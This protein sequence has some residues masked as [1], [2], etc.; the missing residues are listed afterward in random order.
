MFTFP[1]QA[2]RGDNDEDDD[3]VGDE[4]DGDDSEGGYGDSDGGSGF[5]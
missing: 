4:D 2:A 1:T 5:W 3:G